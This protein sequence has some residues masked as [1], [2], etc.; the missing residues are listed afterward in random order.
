MPV[1]TL[2]NLAIGFS[3]GGV[4]GVSPKLKPMATVSNGQK[5]SS[6]H[7]LNRSAGIGAIA[8]GR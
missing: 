1:S 5:D 2:V 7:S 6:W 8:L 4:P 3:L